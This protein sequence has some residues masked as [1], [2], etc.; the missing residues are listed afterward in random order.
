MP[1]SLFCNNIANMCQQKIMHSYL[2]EELHNKII[3]YFD[4]V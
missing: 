1:N 3:Q 4:E 2:S